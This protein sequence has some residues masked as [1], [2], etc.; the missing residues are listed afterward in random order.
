[1]NYIKRLI[2]KVVNYFG[3]DLL[4]I[5]QLPPPPLLHFSIDLMFDVG[6]NVGQ[7]ALSS[8][9]T[10]FV[11]RIISFEPLS[12]AYRALL[13]KSSHDKNWT[14]HE[15]CAVG[16]VCGKKEINIAKNSYSSS[17][18]PMLQA[19]SSAAPESV[20]I[21]KEMVKVIPLDSIYSHY[22][23]TNEKTFLKI[24]A[25][26]YEKE[27]LDGATE[28]LKSIKVVQLELSVVPLYGLQPLYDYFFEFFDAHGFELWSLIP[29]FV[30]QKTGRM[31]Q[32]DAIFVRKT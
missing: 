4:R 22:S 1:M 26:G 6:A 30:D 31:L 12:D 5:T 14:V 7:F 13:E 16:A 2:K 3:F 11:G 32:F 28:S 10:G 17:L 9:G 24:D 19:H 20:Y 21:G 8:R 29:G 18:L 27:I 25:Q 15:R 23:R